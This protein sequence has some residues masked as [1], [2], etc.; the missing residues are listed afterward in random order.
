MTVR[1]LNEAEVNTLMLKLILAGCIPGRDF[2]IDSQGK[3][4]G[5]PQVLK[6]VKRIPVMPEHYFREEK[7]E[8][9]LTCKA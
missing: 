5:S 9:Y 1:H 2:Q 7:A 6:L 4:W 8:Y 3:V